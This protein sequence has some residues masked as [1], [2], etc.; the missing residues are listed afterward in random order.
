MSGF[1][2]TFAE[3]FDRAERDGE[4]FPH[5]PDALAQIATAA[6]NTLAVRARSA[7]A[8]V[9]DALMEATAGVICGRPD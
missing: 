2:A 8:A 6:L 7:D 9:L 3:R 1:T 4:L 5:A